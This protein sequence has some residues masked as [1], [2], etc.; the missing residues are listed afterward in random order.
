M[1]GRKENEEKMGKKIKK[2][3]EIC[4]DYMTKYYYSLN[5]KSYT[6]QKMYVYYVLDF[7]SFLEK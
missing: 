2:E 1:Q 5:G 3:L 4:P 7:I 6:T